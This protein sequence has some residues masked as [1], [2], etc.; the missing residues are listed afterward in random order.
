MSRKTLL[1]TARGAPI[2]LLRL[3]V[4]KPEADLPLKQSTNYS[5]SGSS[6]KGTQL[7]H[8]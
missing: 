8:D 7:I 2:V 5:P 3:N 4:H 6:K 1:D